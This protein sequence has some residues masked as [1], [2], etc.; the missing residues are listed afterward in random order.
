MKLDRLNGLLV[1]E[2][3]DKEALKSQ[4]D[5][6]NREYDRL[7]EEYSQLERRHTLTGG[8]DKRD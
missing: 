4:C 3:K 1:R 2:R 8:G 5:S 7:T 6:L